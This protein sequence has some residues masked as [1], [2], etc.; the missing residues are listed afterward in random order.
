MLH[1]ALTPAGAST[2]LAK[3]GHRVAPE[4]LSPDVRDGRWLV[5]LPNGLLAWFAATP[6]GLSALRTERSVLRLL[7][8]HCPL[9]EVP[10]LLTESPDECVDVRM[11]VPGH[12]DPSAVCSRLRAEP[13]E[14]VRLGA[15][16]GRMVA[17]WHTRVGATDAA[18]IGL[19]GRPAWPR[20]RGWVRERLSR[21]V[22]DAA[23]QAAADAVMAQY[24]TVIDAAS[25][26]DRTLVH[27]DL[28]LHNISIDA[29][30]LAIRGVFDWE[31][32]CWADRHVDFRYFSLG[33]Y[34]EALLDASLVAY[35][36]ATGVPLSR[37]RIDLYNAA[38]AVSYLAYRD[39]VPADMVWCGRTLAEDLR[40]TRI[41]LARS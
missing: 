1:E 12:H 18:A 29:V 13:D 6:D 15:A 11:P 21:V 40:W 35:E 34:P 26:G 3:L 19:P 25:A 9:V 16:L 32:A 22:T 2:A 5:H 10:R 7:H 36:A 39:G 33:L 28:G 37:P 17:E 8:A 31:S 24:E 20:P 41:A 4:T 14:A 30:T 23:L 38:C 27:T